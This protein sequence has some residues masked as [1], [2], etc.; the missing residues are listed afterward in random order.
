MSTIF[1]KFGCQKEFSSIQFDTS[2]VNVGRLKQAIY[3]QKKLIKSNDFDIIIK[4]ANA[5]TPYEGEQ[6]V[7]P[8]N[9]SVIVERV[10]MG[11]ATGRGAASSS[12]TTSA[13]STAQVK[14][15]G[16]GVT[17]TSGT[18]TSV[19][20]SSNTL[21]P[22]PSSSTVG[23]PVAQGTY[24]DESEKI[25][26]VMSQTTSVVGQVSSLDEIG[27]RSFYNRTPFLPRIPPPNYICYRC[28]QTGHYIQN[29]PTNGDP[30][31]NLKKVKKATGIPKSFLKPVQPEN[32]EDPSTLLMPGGGFAV[33][34]PNEEEFERQKTKITVRY[35]T[36]VSRA[37]QCPMCKQI[38]SNSVIL[39]CCGSS[40]CDSCVPKLIEYND[41]KCPE[42]AQEVRVDQ[43]LPNKKLRDSID[44]FLKMKM[45][46]MDIAGSTDSAAVV[47]GHGHDDSGTLDVVGGHQG[48]A[49][50]EQ[51]KINGIT[52]AINKPN[53]IAHDQKLATDSTAILDERTMSNNQ[54]FGDGRSRPYFQR[55]VRRGMRGL[56][57]PRRGGRFRR[58]FV[59][60][61]RQDNRDLPDQVKQSPSEGAHDL[62]DGRKSEEDVDEDNRKRKRSKSPADQSPERTGDRH[63]I[64]SSDSIRK[65][66]DDEE[67]EDLKSNGKVYNRSDKDDENRE[68]N[69]RENGDA[70]K[71]SQHGDRHRSTYYDEDKGHGEGRQEDDSRHRSS[72]SR[73]RHHSNRDEKQRDDD[74]GY[75]SSLR[76]HDSSSHRRHHGDKEDEEDEL[77]ERSYK[78]KRKN[79]E[80]DMLDD[81]E[82]Y[83]QRHSSRDDKYYNEDDKRSRHSHHHRS[84][85]SSK[86][87]HDDDNDAN[88]HHR[89]HDDE[90]VD[91]HYDDDDHKR[92]SSSHRRQQESSSKYHSS[93]G[94]HHGSSGGSNNQYRSSSS[95]KYDHDKKSNNKS[96]DSNK[97]RNNNEENTSSAKAEETKKENNNKSKFFSDAV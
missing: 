50:K 49:G 63:H 11:L 20:S 43:V 55:G 25:R 91:Q 40:I 76:H 54:Q 79:N 95:T 64:T 74:A 53:I 67:E 26:E 75:S 83:N 9:A 71:D 28:G 30:R 15:P 56:R 92:D 86:H 36:E 39:P 73:G 51:I 58:Q 16:I 81:K 96:I 59:D 3:L 44:E 60:G 33:V 85:S 66:K 65:T 34:V 97:L 48:M 77:G 27:N 41:G 72:N 5:G 6:Q 68:R 46:A 22:I 69:K 82:K 2:V 84:N 19:L 35:G 29:C 17:S 87:R 47:V 8:K 12:F 62:E 78:K 1:Y 42:C 24:Q 89:H 21:Q 18:T 93:S 4:D 38:L 32:L 37:F 45:F 14:I 31:F 61:G 90:H 23:K 94:H 57:G 13:S 70:K 52:D 88:K 80:D 10:P 7:L